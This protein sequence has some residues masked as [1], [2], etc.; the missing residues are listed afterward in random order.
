MI[1]KAYFLKNC[2]QINSKIKIIQVNLNFCN[3]PTNEFMFL[4]EKMYS[5]EEVRLNE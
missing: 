4:E 5:K 2:Y 3:L 1:W